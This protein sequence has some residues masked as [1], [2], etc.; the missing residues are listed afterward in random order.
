MNAST[1][2]GVENKENETNGND[3]SQDNRVPPL[4]Q[5]DPL[6]EGVDDGKFV[7]R[8]DEALRYGLEGAALL[9]QILFRSHS[10]GDLVVDQAFAVP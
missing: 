5:V 9:R 2:K 8:V 10:D 1:S 4:P 3:R 6:D 7:E